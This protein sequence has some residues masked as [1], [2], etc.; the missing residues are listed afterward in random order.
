MSAEHGGRARAQ[1]F[2]GAWSARR[3]RRLRWRAL[4]DDRDPGPIVLIRASHDHPVGSYQE[5][6]GLQDATIA[7]ASVT[8]FVGPNGAGKST[9]LRALDW[10]FNGRTGL[11]SERDCYF[12][13]SHQDIR[14]SSFGDA[15]RNP[16]YSRYTHSLASQH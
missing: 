2:T 16:Y 7:F 13:A 10:Y 14:R 12:G 6:P 1:T 4:R 3:D 11:L 15:S 8:T 9:V 5:F